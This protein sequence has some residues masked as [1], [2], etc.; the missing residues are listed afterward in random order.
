MENNNRLILKLGDNEKTINLPGMMLGITKSDE[1]IY[2]L[3]ALND[4]GFV[5][6]IRN[7]ATKENY[8]AFVMNDFSSIDIY[9]SRDLDKLIR[10]DEM[11]KYYSLLPSVGK[12][13]TYSEAFNG[14]IIE[15]GDNEVIHL[16]EDDYRSEDLGYVY[17]NGAKDKLLDGDQ[18][19]K[20]I[21][22]YMVGNDIYESEFK[23]SFKKIAKEA[24]LKTSGVSIAKIVYF[25][26]D[27]VVLA[28]N[29]KAFIVGDAGYTN[30][31]IDL[32]KDKNN[33]TVYVVDLGIH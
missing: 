1:L 9:H 16:G 20:T 23:I 18:Q 6:S 26:E 24:G 17:I 14:S 4:Y 3:V 15:I 30:V 5:L 8:Y 25:N 31:I 32:Q 27:Y 13:G 2:N 11:T 7:F 21:E 12:T 29:Y 19:I 10:E 28:L 22:N 33:P